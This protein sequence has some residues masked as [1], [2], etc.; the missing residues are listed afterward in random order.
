MFLSATNAQT[1][2]TRASPWAAGTCTA[3]TSTASGSISQTSNLGTTFFR[4][5]PADPAST[6]QD[7]SRFNARKPAAVTPAGCDQSQ[8]RGGGE[9][10]H[11]QRHEMQ[12]QV[13]RP[14][15]LAAQLPQRY[16]EKTNTDMGNSAAFCGFQEFVFFLQAMRSARKQRG[17]LRSIRVS[18]TTRSLNGPSPQQPVAAR[19]DCGGDSERTTPSTAVLQVG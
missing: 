5:A 12:L 17:G 15:N 8:L 11:Q 4:Q 10:L 7:P 1:S 18:S 16:G 2:A 14:S 19:P 13:R 3:T 9:R 6:S